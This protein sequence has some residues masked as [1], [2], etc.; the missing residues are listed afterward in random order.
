SD[1]DRFP[2][3][4]PSAPSRSLRPGRLQCLR[5]RRG[6]GDHRRSGGDAPPRVDDDRRGGTVSA[7]GE[8]GFEVGGWKLGNAEP[9]F[10]A[11]N[12]RNRSG[13]GIAG[14]CR[15]TELNKST[16]SPSIG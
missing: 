10:C 16:F 14:P 4:A 6:H 12:R 9:A 11:S 5:R 2:K 8:T 7:G 1:P 13:K 15:Q 3:T